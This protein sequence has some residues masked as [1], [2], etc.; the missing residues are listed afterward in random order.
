MKRVLK[1]QSGAIL[2]TYALMLTAL[3]GFVALGVEAGRWYL[4]RSELSKAVDAAAMSGAKN[5]S[6]PNVDPRTI[7]EEIGKENFPAGQL[8]TAAAGEGSVSFIPSF[9]GTKFQVVGNVSA[10]SILAQVFGIQQ[11]PTSSLGVAQIKEVEIMMVLDKSNSMVSPSPT[12]LTNLK[13]AALSFVSFFKE[14]E[15]ADKMGLITFN[16]TASVDHRLS[17]YFVNDMTAKINAITSP[18]GKMRATNAEEAI[19]RSDNQAAGGFTDQTGIPEDSRVQQYLIFF[20]D[21]NPT[22][23]RDSFTYRGT[24]Y[25]GVAY[26]GPGGVNICDG[27]GLSDPVTGD[28][29]RPSGLPGGVPATPTGDGR[30]TSSNT[31]WLVFA[32]YPAPSPYGPESNI[33]NNV[34]GN[35][36]IDTAKKKAIKHATELKAKGIKIYA[37]GLGADVD[38]PFLRDNIA[39]AGP[40]FYENAPTPDKLE[41]IFNR[42]AKEIRLRLVQ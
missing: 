18:A 13:A 40:G 17:T 33:P 20:T 35:Y 36:L 27:T 3:L 15:A 25:D 38:E 14:T 8:G 9:V 34:L 12:P 5:I 11:V 1:N 7:A 28:T 22:A 10:V 2:I 16:T 21:G 4:V 42:I 37:I 39:S 31:K 19:D 41:A 30:A 32:E 6:N 29:L 23:F 24:V 26:A